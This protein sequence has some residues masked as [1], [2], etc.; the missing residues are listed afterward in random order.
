MVRTGGG[1][2][3]G[4]MEQRDRNDIKKRERVSNELD[5]P[6]IGVPPQSLFPEPPGRRL[7]PWAQQNANGTDIIVG[8]CDENGHFQ[9][10]MLTDVQM[11]AVLRYFMMAAT[12]MPREA[13]PQLNGLAASL[14]DGMAT[15]VV[16][17]CAY[18]RE[19]DAGSGPARAA[20]T[21]AIWDAV[22]EARIMNPSLHITCVDAPANITG[23][24]LSKV[25][26]QPLSNHRELAFYEGTWY[27]PQITNEKSLSK[28]YK[29]F[30]KR[31]K[32]LWHT[33][34]AEKERSKVEGRATENFKRQAFTWRDVEEPFYLRSWTQIYT[35]ESYVK[36]DEPM[37][38]RDFTG[39][40]VHHGK[41]PEVP[42]IMEGSDGQE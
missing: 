22:R 26:T 31:E 36:M 37:I 23:A 7:S 9:G 8:S 3:A 4:A 13:P 6:R 38:R 10:L 28:Q 16:T 27:I 30:N 12:Y 24:Q 34:V 11:Q 41:V 5:I 40:T 32:P 14:R 29:E 1:G 39:P 17:R 42:R 18:G 19:L 15:V 2:A 25:L 35:D 33:K 21:P 20:A